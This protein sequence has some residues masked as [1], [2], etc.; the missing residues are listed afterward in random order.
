MYIGARI[1]QAGY[2][3]VVS[4]VP[5]PIIQQGLSLSEFLRT[6]R[7]WIAFSLSGL[8]PS[9][10]LAS[11]RHAVFFWVGL[12]LAVV[13]AFAG[14]WGAFALAVLVVMGTSWSVLDAHE[15]LGCATR[16]CR[17]RCCS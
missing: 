6:Y 2:R 15:R 13:A 8:E 16:G 14:A 17:S 5:A 12:L 11:F 3:N 4:A 9:F 10:T 1:R 7:R